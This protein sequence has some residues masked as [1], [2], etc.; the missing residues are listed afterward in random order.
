MKQSKKQSLIESMVQTIIGL[1]TSL[2]LQMTLYP[3]LG[4]PV[5]FNQNLI[6]TGAFFVVSIIRGYF[7]RR[8]F[9]KK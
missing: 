1:G 2:A 6:I 4:I 3:V 5:S 7:I 9:N 8:I